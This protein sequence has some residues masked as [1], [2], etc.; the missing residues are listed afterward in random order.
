MKLNTDASIDDHGRVGLGAVLR[1]HNGKVKAAMSCMGV[2]QTDIFHAECMT[3]KKG[4]RWLRRF[5]SSY[6]II[7]TDASQVV[8]A[9]LSGKEIILEAGIDVATIRS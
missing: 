2:R 4:L 3:I 7:E 8:G 1:D 9:I 6:I 5:N